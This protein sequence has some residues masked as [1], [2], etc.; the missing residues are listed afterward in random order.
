MKTIMDA[1]VTAGIGI[2]SAVITVIG[3]EL[4]GLIL[5]KKEAIALKVGVDKYNSTKNTAIDVWHMVDENFRITPSLEKSF[6]NKAAEFN[7]ILKSKIPELTDQQIEDIRQEIAGE[8]NSDK[9]VVTS[10]ALNKQAEI[11]NVKTQNAQ[12]TAENIQLKQKLDTIQNA[13]K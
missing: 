13:V 3:K 5:K 4:R 10:D 2:I 7:K 6:E 12:L 9:A 1:V 11:N 8:M